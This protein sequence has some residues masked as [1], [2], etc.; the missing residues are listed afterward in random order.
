MRDQQSVTVLAEKLA[1]A[2]EAKQDFYNSF[3]EMMKLNR[4]QI[5]V[6]NG[7]LKAQKDYEKVVAE[8]YLQGLSIDICFGTYSKDKEVQGLKVI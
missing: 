6:L 3:V 7:L 2:H 8:V 4:A 1:L 5:Y